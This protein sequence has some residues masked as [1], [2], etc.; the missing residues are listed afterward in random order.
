MLYNLHSI[1]IYYILLTPIC[2]GLSAKKSV[3]FSHLVIS[4]INGENLVKQ[5]V[6]FMAYRTKNA[7][8]FYAML[9]IGETVNL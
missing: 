1:P 9:I 8:V 5:L 2:Q 6:I 4:A 7:T 3:I